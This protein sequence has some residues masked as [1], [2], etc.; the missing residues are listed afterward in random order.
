MAEENKQGL[1]ESGIPRLDR[2]LRADEVVL[3]VLEVTKDWA[4]MK[5][6]PKV[7]VVRS[8]LEEYEEATDVSPYSSRH[9][10]CGRSLYCSVGLCG[11]WENDR[12]YRDACAI[13]SYHLNADPAQ[14]EC[15]SS[16]IA[17]AALWGVAAP[18]L[19][20]PAFRFTKDQVQIN[21]VATPDGQRIKGYVLADTLT[22]TELAYEDGKISLAQFTKRNGDKL[23]WQK[24]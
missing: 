7:D 16:F 10:A 11:V 19:R 20:M 22:C 3:Q 13:G 12:V 21:P 23:L 8:I 15:D 24:H 9:Y 18:V 2:P 6:W 4:K 17:A 1:K 14:N 5:L